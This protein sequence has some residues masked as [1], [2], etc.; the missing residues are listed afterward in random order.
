M[1]MAAAPALVVTAG[2]SGHHG[3]GLSGGG[4]GS[5]VVHPVFGAHH[6]VLDDDVHS[7]HTSMESHSHGGTPPTS[8]NV[9]VGGSCGSATE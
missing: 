5:T 8:S 1:A 9:G 2:G 7:D 6:S 3:S 4:G